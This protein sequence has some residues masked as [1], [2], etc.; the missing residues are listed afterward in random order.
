[1]PDALLPT[2]Y[3][4]PSS[5]RSLRCFPR[6]GFS[7]QIESLLQVDSDRVGDRTT[8]ETYIQCRRNLGPVAVD[9]SLP[10]LLEGLCQSLIVL[11][12]FETSLHHPLM[13]LLEFLDKPFD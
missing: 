1:M 10:K 5:P 13:Q 3:Y 4:P 6:D 11:T 2:A 7:V 8:L 9:A 12:R